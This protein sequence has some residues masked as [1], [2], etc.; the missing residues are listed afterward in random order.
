MSDERKREREQDQDRER[1][2]ESETVFPCVRV[3]FSNFTRT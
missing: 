3:Y 2:R 1:E